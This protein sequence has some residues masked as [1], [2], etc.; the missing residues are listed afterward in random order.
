[1]GLKSAEVWTKLRVCK[2]T[3]MSRFTNWRMKSSNNTSQM[4]LRRMRTSHPKWEMVDFNLIPILEQV[5]HKIQAIWVKEGHHSN[6]NQ[7]IEI[8]MDKRSQHEK[9][10]TMIEKKILLQCM[11]KKSCCFE[12]KKTFK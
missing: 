12:K 11:E 3:K 10:F 4:R 2:I 8:N 1:M 5:V 9:D 7:K 6:F